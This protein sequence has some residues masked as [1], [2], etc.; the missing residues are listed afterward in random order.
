MQLKDISQQNIANA[1]ANKVNSEPFKNRKYQQVESKVAQNL[2]QW[3]DMDEIKPN[4]GTAEKRMM[5]SNSFSAQQRRLSYQKENTQQNGTNI[6]FKGAR[7]NSQAWNPG[8]LKESKS[9]L[10]KDALDQLNNMNR[11]N[12]L[13]R[14]K[15]LGDF[16]NQI[17]A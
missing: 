13:N 8:Y 4:Y 12:I 3:N 16:G 15:K 14:Q 9:M 2:K 5:K 7:A 11:T 1:L 17:I 10:N 6:P